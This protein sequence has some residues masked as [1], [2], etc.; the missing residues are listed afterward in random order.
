MN[1]TVEP[2]G[3]GYAIYKGRD[4]AHHGSNLGLLSECEDGLP[5]LIE[6]A[7]NNSSESS[8]EMRDK[9]LSLEFRLKQEQ[10]KNAEHEQ[11]YL[12]VW[13]A[14][15]EPNET[16]LDAVKRVIKERDKA[17]LE[18]GSIQNT[19]AEALDLSSTPTTADEVRTILEKIK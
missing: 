16:V 10:A 2:H 18:L 7:L 11:D 14:I 8:Q 3:N 17:L 9:L 13:K 5:Q 1:Y 12:A 6:S 4:K 15:K 19:I